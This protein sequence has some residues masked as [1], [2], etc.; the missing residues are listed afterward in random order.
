MKKSEFK[1]V[2]A[3]ELIKIISNTFSPTHGM[4]FQIKIKSNNIY[5]TFH[6]Y[7][8]DFHIYIFKNGNVQFKFKEFCHGDY[9]CDYYQFEEND[10]FEKLIKVF[11]KDCKTLVKAF[12]NTPGFWHVLLDCFSLDPSILD[13]KMKRNDYKWLEN[14][15]LV[16]KECGLIYL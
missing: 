1:V 3:K 6:R 7:G 2:L 13:M 16:K 9:I 12:V 5:F 8:E 11:K 15:Q 4:D 10:D 14:F